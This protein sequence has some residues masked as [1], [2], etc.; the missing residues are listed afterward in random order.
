MDEVMPTNTVA[1]AQP[2]AKIKVRIKVDENDKCLNYALEADDQASVPYVLAGNKID[3]PQGP[4]T[5]IEFK[6]QGPLGGQL[7]FNENDPIWVSQA[8]CPQASSTDPSVTI[9]DCKN[10]KLEISD[11]NLDQVDLHYRLNFVDRTGGDHYWDPI[12]RN[13]GGGP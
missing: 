13:G 5:T 10:N 12:I 1:A 2:I 3:V 11:A 7:D 9:V 6:I 4:T 8:G